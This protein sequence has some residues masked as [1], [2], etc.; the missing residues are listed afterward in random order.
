M[1]CPWVRVACEGSCMSCRN[2]LL[3][4]SLLYSVVGRE[5]LMG[6]RALTQEQWQMQKAAVGAISLQLFVA[7]ANPKPHTSKT[8]GVWNWW[9]RKP[10][11]RR[12]PNLRLSLGADD[13]S[14][15]FPTCLC[16][17]T[18]VLISWHSFLNSYKCF[19]GKSK[20][21]EHQL[22]H[23]LLFRVLHM[24]ILTEFFWT[25]VTLWNKH[26]YSILKIKHL[27]L[28]KL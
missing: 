15:T 6:N 22:S 26:G 3:F 4:M 13:I 21:F 16:S 12:K 17:M 5:L 1:G 27:R 18:F 14:T 11:Y 2:K 7:T 10:I 24:Q 23:Q 25:K 9:G 20:H 8:L 19:K 28:R